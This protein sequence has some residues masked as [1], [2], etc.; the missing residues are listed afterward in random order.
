[1]S[2]KETYPAEADVLRL[3]ADDMESM[4]FGDVKSV[5]LKVDRGL[6]VLLLNAVISGVFEQMPK[7]SVD[8]IHEAAYAARSGEG[9]RMRTMILRMRRQS[10]R[11]ESHSNPE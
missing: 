11:L 2:T 1:M 8:G 9:Y 6:A 7:G 10:T 5:E 4:L 3:L